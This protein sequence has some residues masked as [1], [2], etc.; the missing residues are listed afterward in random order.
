MGQALFG[1][2]RAPFSLTFNSGG[3]GTFLPLFFQLMSEV[4]QR[5]QAGGNNLARV[6]AD[7]RLSQ[8]AYVDPSDP[9]TLYLSQPQAAPNSEQRTAFE[10]AEPSAPPAESQG[11]QG[12]DSNCVCS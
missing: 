12:G 5:Q 4:H 1:G 7:G 6:A 3:C 11:R 9:S 8:V 2:D 10:V